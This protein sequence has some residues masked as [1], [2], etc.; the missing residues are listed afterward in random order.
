[1]LIYAFCYCSHSNIKEE[2]KSPSGNAEASLREALAPWQS[3]ANNSYL[4]I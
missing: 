3:R 1:M 2:T 4:H